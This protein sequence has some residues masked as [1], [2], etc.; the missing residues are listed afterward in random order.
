MR[1][2]PSYGP[3]DL[4]ALLDHWVA[5]GVITPEQAARMRADLPL[6]RRPSERTSLVIEALGYLGGVIILIALALLAQQYWPELSTTARLVIVAGAA[7]FLLV[8]GFAVPARLGPA[9]RRLHAM[10]WLAGTV[11][12]A[13]FLGL[14]GHDVLVLRGEDLALLTVGGTA[15]LAAVLWWRL[16]TVVQQAAMVGTLAGTAGVAT[17]QV[18]AAAD[19]LSGVAAWGVGV[20][21]FLL[22]WGGVLRPRRVA[23]ALGALVMVIGSGFTMSAD[24]GIVLA[25]GT[26]AAIVVVAV[27]FRD[28][29]LLAVGAWG[30]LQTLPT[31]VGEWFPGELAAAM[32]LLVTG[33]LLV[34]AAVSTARRSRAGHRPRM[35]GDPGRTARRI[36]GVR[37]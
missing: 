37:H 10:L 27:L 15:L 18:G 12:T 32:A 17:L 9:G 23:L 31:A 8:G 16:P 35:S 22:G 5:A 2:Q 24:A 6:P 26:V 34:L 4:P 20:G 14:F 28:L 7:V 30:A 11:A 33:A 19:E 25:L 13:G 29:V 1:Q 36:P 3:A 21:W